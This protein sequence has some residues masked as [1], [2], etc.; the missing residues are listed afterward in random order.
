[1]SEKGEMES[2]HVIWDRNILSSFIPKAKLLNIQQQ[3]QVRIQEAPNWT[4]TAWVS[5][6]EVT[7][8]DTD[9][10]LQIL[11][12][13]E[14]AVTS[15]SKSKHIY[16]N[17]FPHR[18]P[19]VC[20]NWL[21]FKLGLLEHLHLA[22]IDIVQRVNGLTGLLDVLANAVW[23]P[24]TPQSTTMLETLPASSAATQA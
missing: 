22:D 16:S 15:L 6:L 24:E 11:K 1:M 12:I 10:L 7:Q 21:T 2:F 8:Q 20:S 18:P 13:I 4:L 9:S 14:A 17:S 19:S 23:D 3:F 5:I